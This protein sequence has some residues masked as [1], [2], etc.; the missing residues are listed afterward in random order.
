[1]Y[2]HSGVEEFM[3]SATI[4]TARKKK[5]K[6][7]DKAVKIDRVIA[8]KAGLVAESKGQPLA[9]YVTEILRGPVERDWARAVRTIDT[10]PAP[11]A[12]DN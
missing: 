7:N 5:P 6:R 1:M 10:L 9:E 4:I 11:A 2:Q 8:M 12:E 3:A